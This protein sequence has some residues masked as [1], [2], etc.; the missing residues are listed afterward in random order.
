MIYH[1]PYPELEIPNIPFSTFALRHAGRLADKPAL[2]DA[3]TGRSVTF[4]EL[5][6]SVE[7]V[8]AGLSER[9]VQQHDVVAL[10]APNSI[11]YIIAFHAITVLG[12]TVST[13]NP[14]FKEAELERQLT[15]H[16]AKFIITVSDLTGLV[17]A[18]TR[19][20][21]LREIFVIGESGRYTS[22]AVLLASRQKIPFVSID[23]RNDI[24]ALLSS[25]GTTGMPKG[26]ILTH[27]ALISMGLQAG[28]P[29]EL[30]EDDIIPGNLPLF[31]A[32]AVTITLST[33]LSVGATSV[34]LPRFDFERFLRLIQDYRISRVY[35]VPPI[36]I[37]LAKQPVVDNYDLSSLNVIVSA[38]A[39][40]GADIERAVTDRIGCVVKQLHGMTECVPVFISPDDI[41]S[42]KQGSVG[43]VAPDTAVRIVDP[44]TG[45]DCAP[46]RRGEVLVRG[47]QM[48]TGYLK[49]PSA[50]SESIDGDGW[51]HTGDLAYVDE[52]GYFYIVDR[53]K[54]LI[55]YKGYQVAPAEIE[56]V[57][58]SH[59]AVADV[60]VV[61]FPDPESGEVPKAFV[62]AK[63]PIE[64]DELMNWVAERV[65]PY[66]KVRC[67]AFID[68][69]PKSASGKILRRELM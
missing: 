24:A 57:L 40:L 44:E 18:A 19:N 62:V 49:N 29:H 50:T 53:L 15:E 56:A 65:A 35:A 12:A 68:A 69:I 34:I 67:I 66:K 25:S 33:A 63:A 47:P 3:T 4:G 52:D 28:A 10:F 58:L 1:S 41:P 64:A 21:S 27:R 2:I 61:R 23:P 32:Y 36:L 54:E 48:M 38:A 60:A 26:V 7:R 11:E 13:I 17:S 30:R 46:G 16:N 31:H 5:R 22:F 43:V 45:E 14:L 39:P 37:A 42:C 59:P 55:K 6:S 51:L 20:R 8:A 9:G